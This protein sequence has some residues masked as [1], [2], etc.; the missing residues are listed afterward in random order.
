MRQRTWFLGLATLGPLV[1]LLLALVPASASATRSKAGSPLAAPAAGPTFTDDFSDPESGWPQADD[2]TATSG[3]VNG[4]FRLLV[5]TVQTASWVVGGPNF[6]DVDVEATGRA[7]GSDQD[8]SYGLLFGARDLATYDAFQIDPIDGTF[9]LLAHTDQGWTTV[10][11]WAPSPSILRNTATNTLRVVRRGAAITLYANG[12]QLATVSQPG[13][14]AGRLGLLVANYADSAGAEVYFDDL[15]AYLPG[16]RDAGKTLYLPRA[17]RG[18][19]DVVPHPT[20]APGPTPGPGVYGRVTLNSAPAAGIA[21]SL[22]QYDAAGTQ[23][24][25]QTTTAADGH[26][27]FADAP[28]APAGKNYFVLFGPNTT[29]PQMV[30]SWYAPDI[31]DFQQLSRRAGGDFDVGDILLNR[32]LAN[33]SLPAPITFRWF[34]RP[35]DDTYAVTIFEPS[36]GQRWTSAD[37]GHV[38]RAAIGLPVGATAGTTYGWSM[39]AF[40]GASSFGDAFYYNAFAFSRSTAAERVDVPGTL[41]AGESRGHVAPA[42]AKLRLADALRAASG[43]RAAAP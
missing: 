21:L 8:K 11:D 3:Y 1:V 18:P 15:R 30:F 41:T 34:E 5:K 2:A 25:A 13:V 26:Y 17:D 24:V 33:A 9:A 37:L 42:V 40:V 7:V 12:D 27:L 35:A 23:L 29:D 28:S 31:P 14:S 38:D 19:A 6:G 20:V 39:R 4:A 22:Q 32:P 43:P 16:E 36:G 10:L